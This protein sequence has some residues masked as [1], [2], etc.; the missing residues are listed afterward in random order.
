MDA[1][2][3]IKEDITERSIV[4]NIS[5]LPRQGASQHEYDYR[6]CKSDLEG[7][8][9]HYFVV[10]KIIKYNGR[11]MDD[12]GYVVYA[13]DTEGNFVEDEGIKNKCK[14]KFFESLINV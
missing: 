7:L 9:N 10:S 8:E 2:E 1:L 3:K 12:Y 4:K 11:S 5:L 13:Y 6:I 14:G